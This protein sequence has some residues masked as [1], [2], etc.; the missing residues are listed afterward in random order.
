MTLEQAHELQRRE[1]MTLRAENKRLYKQSSGLFSNK[2]KETLERHIRHLEQM[3]KTET[4]RHESARS[5]WKLMGNRCYDLELENIDLK[6]KVAALQDEN[7]SLRQRAENSEKEV[8]M[9][10]GTN[11]KLEKKL[12]TNFENSSLPSSALPFRKKVPN[13]RKPSGKKPGGQLGHRPHTISRLQTTKEPVY[14][15]AP[16]SFISNSD[17]YATGKTVTKQL[18]D[19]C[20][21]VNVRDY[22]A[23][24]Y[25]NRITGTKLHAPFPD[26]IVN[27]VNYGSSVKAFTFLLNNYYNVSI[28]KTKQCLS[29]ITKGIVNLSTGTI[30][31][32]C[33]EFSANTDVERAKI[34]SLLTHSNVLHSDATVSNING[35]RKAVILTTNKEQVLYQHLDHKGHDGL[36]KTPILN[37]NGTIIHDHDRSYY[38]YGSNHQ[39]CLAHV[40]RYLV[41][42]IENEPQLTW[43]KQMHSLLQHMI[44]VAKCNK[45]GIPIDKVKQM[46]QKY[47]SILITASNEYNLYP[48]LKEYMDGFNLQKRL[49]KHQKDHLYF[50]KHLEVDFTNNIS[51]R[52]LRKFKRKQKQAVVFR[53]DTGGQHVCD[54]LTI[55]ETARLQHRNV[56]A[57]IENVFIK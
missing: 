7:S 24:E 42:A 49:K 23:D 11:K 30:C 32:L 15:P 18:I 4:T 25:R 36:S 33:S 44:H 47:E 52:G 35:S 45:N 9:L 38:S 22:I 3:I 28:S 48:P 41:G 43:H 16:L 5:N 1:L 20:I 21:T 17:I 50:L 26:G 6:D 29:D 2:E 56:Y 27:D 37:F 46:T 57:T 34:F 51:E 8:L 13:S 31:N 54:A 40:L 19:I 55:I 10:N 12:G 53:S 14:L 39:E